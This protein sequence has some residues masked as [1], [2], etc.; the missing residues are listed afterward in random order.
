MLFNFDGTE[1]LNISKNIL[2]NNDIIYENIRPN[3]PSEEEWL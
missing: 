3:L 1:L 2:K